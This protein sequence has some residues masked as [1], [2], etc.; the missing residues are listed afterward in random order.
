MSTIGEPT[1]VAA[2]KQPNKDRTNQFQ[3]KE[4]HAHK[5]HPIKLQNDYELFLHIILSLSHQTGCFAIQRSIYLFFYKTVT[6]W[7]LKSQY[8]AHKWT[9]FQSIH[10]SFYINWLPFFV[11]QIQDPYIKLITWQCTF[12][13]FLL[14]PL[15]YWI[16]IYLLATFFPSIFSLR[17]LFGWFLLASFATNCAH[18]ITC[19]YFHVF[20]PLPTC[21]ICRQLS[22]FLLKVIKRYS[23][24]FAQ[25]F[26]RR[27]FLFHTLIVLTYLIVCHL[28]L[29]WVFFSSLFAVY[30]SYWHHHHCCRRLYT[31]KKSTNKYNEKTIALFCLA[32][33]RE[34]T[35]ETLCA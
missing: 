7:L 19:T 31:I 10:F 5:Y 18:L 6:V 30:F 22:Y 13:F 17:F 15:P 27:L 32:L 21:F 35:N 28:F 16:A 24:R 1:S 2:I 3:I 29:R 26:G 4:I 11:A 12:F 34:F 8:S 20:L 23:S 25:N 33:F 14:S 9:V